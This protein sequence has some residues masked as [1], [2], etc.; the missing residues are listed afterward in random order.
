MLSAPLGEGEDRER[1]P[2]WQDI[3]FLGFGK[4]RVM[5]EIMFDMQSGSEVSLVAGTPSTFITCK[6]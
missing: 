1:E 5:S 2:S 3:G 4:D 6:S